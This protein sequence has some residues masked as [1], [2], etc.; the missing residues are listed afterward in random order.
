MMTFHSGGI[1]S[2]EGG[3]DEA[4]GFGGGEE[5]VGADGSAARF[6]HADEIFVG[7]VRRRSLRTLR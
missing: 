3:F 7:G 1:E 2:P 6:F 4:S 5:G